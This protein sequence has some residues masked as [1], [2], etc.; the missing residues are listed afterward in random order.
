[1]HRSSRS[2]ALVFAVAFLG[3]A[4]SAR[5]ASITVS[6]HVSS[7][8]SPLPTLL[9]QVDGPGLY[10]VGADGQGLRRLAG[11]AL[12]PSWSPDGTRIAYVSPSFEVVIIEL[13]AGASR[14]VGS[15]VSTFDAIPSW[16]PDGRYLAYPGPGSGWERDAW[17]ADASGAG[18]PLRLVRPGDD[19]EVAWGP[20]G[21]L[22]RAGA[23]IVV[24]DADG[25]NAVQIHPG[26]NYG[27]LK[28]SPDGNALVYLPDS[29]STDLLIGADGSNPRT[30]ADSARLGLSIWQA[31]WSPS[32][33]DLAYYE[34]AY[35]TGHEVIGVASADGGPGREIATDAR[36]PVWS[37]RGDAIAVI[38]DTRD[39]ATPIGGIKSSLTWGDQLLSDL[40]LMAPD[41]QASRV[42]VRSALN[43]TNPAWS[44]DGTTLVF[45]AR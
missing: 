43:L 20:D 16:S 13:A 31:D 28:W 4:V 3:S 41:G 17:I 21:R 19:A 27:P 7:S 38:K 22:A 39:S 1:M 8:S 2:V 33:R 9:T 5:A 30:L 36:E 23:G 15:G 6:A 14:V 29:T 35:R 18:A 26:G 24:S 11:P 40:V 45:V 12:R 34:N 25:A 37:P 10:L 42:I 44:P 32:S